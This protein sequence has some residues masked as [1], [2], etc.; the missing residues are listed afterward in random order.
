MPIPGKIVAA[1]ILV[2]GVTAGTYGSAT[3]SS[4]ITV[5]A[6]GQVTS[7]ANVSVSPDLTLSVYANVT[8]AAGDLVY[9]SGWDATSGLPTIDFADADAPEKAATYVCDA[10]ILTTASGTVSKLLLS[11]ATLNTNSFSAIGSSVYLSTTATTG[12]TWTTA[13]TGADVIQQVV[14]KVVVKSATVGQIQFDLVDAPITKAGTSFLQAS[15]TLTTP[16]FASAGHID[17]ANGNELVL[18]PATVA[19]AVNEFTISNAAASGRPSILA[20]GGDT[21]IDVVIGGKGTGE[22][23]LGQ[24]TSTGVKLV[25]DQPIRDSNDNELIKFTATGSAVN[26]I[27]VANGASGSAI[28]P[29]ISVS[30]EANVPLTLTA[31]GIGNVRLGQTGTLGVQLVADQPLLDSAGLELVKFVKTATAANEITVTNAALGGSPKIAAT[32]DDTDIALTL[33]AKGAGNV[34]LQPITGTVINEKNAPQLTLGKNLTAVTIGTIALKHGQASG[35]F[36][37]VQS[38]DVLTASRSYTWPNVTGVVQVSAAMQTRTIVDLVDTAPTLTAAQMTTSGLLTGVPT[39]PR[40]WQSATAADI[41]AIIGTTTGIWFDFSIVSTG[42]AN[43]ITLTVNTGIT[44]TGSAVVLQTG[45]TGSGTW[46]GVVT[47]GT[48]VTLFRIA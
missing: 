4:Q 21:N 10:A 14:G 2:T 46:R 26:E 33:A 43:T 25:A 35:D 9:L 1:D 13:P 16:R 44:I 8:V 39:A 47:S 45:G 19:S 29:T 48:T 36:Q 38:P 15:L 23:Q 40:N 41:I 22:V 12:N 31:K 34:I 42:G 11:A 24:A 3:Q 6:Q 20:T 27:T 30:G 32:G 37:G 5:N 7:A 17:D 28:G 18:F